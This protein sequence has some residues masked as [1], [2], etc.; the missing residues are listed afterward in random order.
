[1]SRWLRGSQ[2]LGAPHTAAHHCPAH[3]LPLL[4]QAQEPPSTLQGSPMS[5]GL[6]DPSPSPLC[7]QESHDRHGS[8]G[9]W[10]RTWPRQRGNRMG[11]HGLLS[12]HQL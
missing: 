9:A 5:M 10:M 2:A 8:A 11:Q 3:P 6:Q 4:C 1:M 12:S 7:C